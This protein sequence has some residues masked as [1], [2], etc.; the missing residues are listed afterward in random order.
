MR[1]GGR[2]YREERNVQ[3]RDMG[4]AIERKGKI[5]EGPKEMEWEDQ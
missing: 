4:G 5:G 1:R 3:W 2:S